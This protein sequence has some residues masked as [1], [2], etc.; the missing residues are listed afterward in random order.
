MSHA[1]FAYQPTLRQLLSAEALAEA[2][3]S[4][5]DH[6]L[7]RAVTQVVSTLNPGSR[8]GS[9]YVNLAE[10]VLGKPAADFRELSA[11]I[12]IRS[13]SESNVVTQKAASSDIVRAASPVL[14]PVVS[15]DAA[16]KKLA[17]IFKEAEVPLIVLPGLGDPGQIA[18]E[19]R[20]AF[21]R[22]LK[23][24]NSRLH[25]HLLSVVVADGLDGLVE[26]VSQ[27][28]NRPVVV[29]NTE[30]ELLAA[31]NMGAT[32]ANQQK[33]I[34]DE[35]SKKVKEQLRSPD[36][37]DERD[38]IVQPIKVG[39]RLV[40]PILLGEAVVGYISSMVRVGDDIEAVAEY[41][42]PAALAAMIDFHERRKDTSIFAATHK[43]LLKDLLSGHALSAADQERLEQHFG[44]DLCD[45]MLVFAVEALDAAGQVI[46]I[47]A[48]F[49][50][51]VMITEV[52]GTRAVI[53]PYV[54]KAERTWQQEAEELVKSIKETL[55]K[56]GGGEARVRVGSGRP[57][58]TTLDLPDA[59]REA[60]QALI[61]GAMIH[62]D[63]EFVMGYGDLGVKRLLY[64]MIDH[65]EVDRFYE[66]NLA[67]LEAYDEEWESELMPSLRVYLD[68]G[69][70]LNSAARALFIHRHT[71]RY[72]LEQIAE[73]LKV[74]ID[75]QE[76]LQN[77]QIAFHIRD[78][79]GLGKR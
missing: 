32:P 18:D 35:T 72:R 43:S 60:R 56:K 19:V 26:E 58:E 51:K 40:A 15:A 77:L 6:L 42:R 34:I 5:G 4:Y 54:I 9:L 49:D 69:A 53:M 74:D 29:E 46:K 38:I 62:A 14:A 20:L 10:A 55:K 52:E 59:Y 12:V 30:F 11:V 64:L 67:P 70:N 36:R 24:N 61:I 31:R 66:D 76:V 63:A 71:L 48:L 25:G 45:G 22:Q 79:K 1:N 2:Q 41:L 47:D 27:F 75:S 44:L 17:A 37:G 50:D 8:S 23:L 16:L 57:A 68:Q 3:I 7:D 21:L 78:M 33:Q 65:P 28:L 13:V 73:I 39:R